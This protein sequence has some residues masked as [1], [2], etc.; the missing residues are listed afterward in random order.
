MQY[1][2]MLKEKEALSVKE[3][4]ISR[5]LA[6]YPEG[7]L[8]YSHNGKYVKWYRSWKGTKTYI[9]SKDREMASV[10]AEK[11]YYEAV[12]QDILREK[13]AIEKYLDLCGTGKTKEKE[14]LEN[15]AYVEL[16]KNAFVRENRELSEWEKQDYEKC[17]KHPEQLVHAVPMIDGQKVRSKS[18]AIIASLL[19]VNRI[20][21]HYEEALRIGQRVIYPD[22]TIR[23]PITGRIFYWEHFGMMDN[24]NYAQAAFQKMQL[25]NEN[26]IL[27]SDTLLATYESAEIPLKSDIVE[28]IIQ[29]YFLQRSI[30]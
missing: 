15:S 11:K 5:Q 29:Q 3:D 30:T 24:D 7:K 17:P 16:L 12:L 8:I 2:Q 18:E 26:G 27:L 1:Y 28:N 9:P 22:F 23:H 13:Y 10:L 25:Y 19:H 6:T 20:P 4:K 21:F 14:I